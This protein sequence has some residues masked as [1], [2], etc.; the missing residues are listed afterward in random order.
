VCGICVVLL[1]V[2]SFFSRPVPA[3]VWR[4]FLQPQGLA[5]N[6]LADLFVDN[7]GIIWFATL[8][9]I[10][11]FDGQWSTYQK[12]AGL[13]SNLVFAIAKDADCEV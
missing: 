2:S 11:R 9:G 10:S 5:D 3:Q 7:Q 8:N 4:T 1:L 6:S 13:A 12:D